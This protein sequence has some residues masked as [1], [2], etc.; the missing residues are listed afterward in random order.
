VRFRSLL[1]RPQPDLA[2]LRPRA[3]YD[4]SGSPGSGDIHLLK[5]VMDTSVEYDRRRKTPLYARAGVP[6]VWLVDIPAGILD[7]H[8]GPGERGHADVR[9]ARRGERV[10][11]LAFPDVELRVEDILG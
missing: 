2:L 6:E 3:D 1:S 10:S 4:A 11:P 7:V 5:E 9:T 8:R